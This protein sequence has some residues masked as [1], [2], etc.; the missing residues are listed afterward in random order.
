MTAGAITGWNIKTP[1]NRK[2]LRRN[3]A[4]ALSLG[5]AELAH[6][7]PNEISLRVFGNGPTAA[8]APRGGVT[9]AVNGA[10]GLWKDSPGGPNFWAACDPQAHVADFV[11]D[12][13]TG[14]T[15]LVASKCHPDVF[16]ALGRRQVFLWHVAEKATADLV[17]E[18][19]PIVKLPSVT[20]SAFEVG[21]RMG[22]RRFETFGWDGCYFGQQHHA[23]DQA[24]GK[25][26]VQLDVD[27]RT[28]P[29]DTGFMYEAEMAVNYL[30]GFPRNIVVH[31]AGMFGAFLRHQ[32][33]IPDPFAE[34]A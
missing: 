5:L 27:G 25:K 26:I 11:R 14:V 13:P 1:S 12:P 6:S 22:F 33:A 21:H 31:G 29:T 9:I 20:M 10:I 16:D 15:Y 24:H 28:Y 2:E 4:H 30:R 23:V 18:R 7:E 32:G 34:A 19:D 3:V 17:I 8:R